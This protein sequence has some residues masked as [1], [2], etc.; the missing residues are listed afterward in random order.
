M[1]W[2]D[3]TPQSFELQML[4]G[5]PYLLL[6]IFNRVLPTWVSRK[7]IHMGMGWMLLHSDV[8]DARVR[9]AVHFVAWS[10]L[11]LVFVSAF[12]DVALWR[13]L[14]FLH[15]RRVDPGVTTYLLVCSACAAL[16]VRYVD[17]CPLFFADPMGAVVGR[18]LR[19]P[20]LVGNKTWGGTLAVWLTAALTW[21]DTSVASCVFGATLIATTELFA[22]DYDNPCIAG[23]LLVRALLVR[24]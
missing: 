6:C 18:T 16:G 5:A 15:A 17:M 12:A 9:G 23:I 19:T 14:R 1:R 11:A 10:F 4:I 3:P 20:R 21:N 24:A 2:Y 8:A 22:G 7:A 13:H